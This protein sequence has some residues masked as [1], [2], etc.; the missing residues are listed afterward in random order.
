MNINFICTCGR[1]GGVDVGLGHFRRCM[2]LAEE[3]SS[4]G[5][6][7]NFCIYGTEIPPFLKEK[8]IN[9]KNIQLKNFDSF[10][11]E[12]DFNQG[13]KSNITFIDLSHLFFTRH[14]EN[15][16]QLTQSIKNQTEC[17]VLIDSLGKES[18]VLNSKKELLY[19]YLIVPYFG[20]EE[21]FE[22]KNNHLLGPE[23][24]IFES[25]LDYFDQ[26]DIP[27]IAKKICITCGGTDAQNLT[28]LILKGLNR[29][30]IPLKL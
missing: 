1:K 30:E 21:E 29:I 17:L 19:D 5:S 12:K 26:V 20:A 2:T 7:I 13:L 11:K 24:F 22:K 8:K 10:L 27:K 28:P 18:I 14:T 9:L 23:F 25:S 6:Q 16:F 15:F 3:F 4:L